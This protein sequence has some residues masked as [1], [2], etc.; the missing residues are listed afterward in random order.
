MSWFFAGSLL[1]AMAITWAAAYLIRGRA[2]RWNLIDAPAERKVH[3]TPT[4][5]G[6]GVAIWLGVVVPLAA[7]QLVLWLLLKQGMTQSIAVPEFVAVHLDGLWEQSGKLWA[8]LGLGTVLMLLGLVD[9]LRGIDWRVRIAVEIA[10]AVSLVAAGWRLTLFVDAPILTGMVTVV[11]IVGLVN[12]FNMLD[13]MDGLAAGV[14][15]IAA[16]LL[17]AVMLGAGHSA[18]QPQLFIGG[19]LL[20]LIG[21][22]VGFLWHNRP[23][24]RLFMGD[25]GSYFIGYML[26]LCTTMATFAGENTPR[27]AI[28][29][30]LCVLAVPLYDI[31]SVVFIRLRAGRS[32]F[33]A[34]TSHFSHRLVELG[35]TPTKA[36]LT[37]YLTTAATGLGALLL[38]QVNT[39]GAAVILMMVA[40]VLAVI[41]ILETTGRNRRR[42]RKR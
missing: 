25:A 9:D 30:P 32:P 36:V 33:S 17:A 27:H 26:A 24:A 18:D 8:L 2:A 7:G 41:A 5:L 19:L 28:L 20:V 4:P 31:S 29:A 13:N 1:P 37:I 42:R 21:A 35:L 10:V 23:P 16:S 11:W 38:Y 3:T 12:S 40:C 22:L 6:G 14:A 15:A 34:D 39:T